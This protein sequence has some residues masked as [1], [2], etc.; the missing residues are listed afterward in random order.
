[1]A[2]ILYKTRHEVFKEL[3]VIELGNGRI[4]HC[5]F[6][7]SPVKG[8]VVWANKDVL[9]SSLP[10]EIERLVRGEDPSDFSYFVNYRPKQ[11]AETRTAH[12]L[13][14]HAR[15]AMLTEVPPIEF[16]GETYGL[17]TIKGIGH[18]QATYMWRNA[19]SVLPMDQLY[20]VPVPWSIGGKRLEKDDADMTLDEFLE[21]RPVGFGYELQMIHEM[22]GVKL[23]SQYGLKPAHLPLAVIRLTEILDNEGNR[24][25]VSDLPFDRHAP[26]GKL[27]YRFVPAIS[28]RSW[29]DNL[30]VSEMREEDF[31]RFYEENKDRY[32]FKG[33]PDYFAWWGGEI[34]WQTARMHSEGM[35]H[36]NISGINITPDAR[37]QDYADSQAPGFHQPLSINDLRNTGEFAKRVAEDIVFAALSCYD[38]AFAYYNAHPHD[39]KAKV[40]PALT[41]GNSIAREFIKQYEIIN[42]IG[43]QVAGQISG[44]DKLVF[45][46]LQAA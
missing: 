39:N 7:I 20:E 8:Q 27:I 35:T 5:R 22:E 12:S 13:V 42:Q 33:I 25:N 11:G 3:R 41:L 31:Q 19:S 46:L 9:A 37:L 26:D 24:V 18:P 45:D 15:E 44:K 29:V 16:Q 30:R 28:V 43:E 23:V 2:L 1:M 17:T 4:A 32:N 34:G 38:L 36:A 14:A 21:T 40:N 10:S 6:N